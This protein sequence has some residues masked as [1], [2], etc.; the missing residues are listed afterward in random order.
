MSQHVKPLTAILIVI[1]TLVLISLIFWARGEA[2]RVGGPDQTQIDHA[3][4]LYIH[5]S[6]TLYIFS[7]D[8]ALQ[9]KLDLL[10][11]GVVDLVGDFAFFSNGDLLIR[12]GKFDPA[13]I[14]NIRRYQ[15]L[16]ETKAPVAKHKN[17]GMYRCNLEQMSCNK[18]GNNNIDFDSAFHLSVDPSTDTVYLSDTGRHK[19]RKFDSDGNTLAVQDKGFRFPNQ[20]L[21]HNN[22]LLVADTNHHA[23]QEVDT[24]NEN[25]GKIIQTNIVKN[26]SLGRHKWTFSMARVND[27]WW[28]NNMSNNMSN[29][30]I[31]VYDSNWNFV[32][33][34]ELPKKADPIDF[35][36]LQD[37]VLITDLDN[38]AIH[39][40]DY[41]GKL[42]TSPLP[43]EMDIKLQ[44][45]RK[46]KSRYEKL[47]IAAIVLFVLFIAGG[48]AL[49]ILQARRQREPAPELSSDE[50]F[51]DIN[52][53]AIKWVP[54]NKN[55]KYLLIVLIV[56][57]LLLI[58]LSVFLLVQSKPTEN[59]DILFPVIMLIA[60][61]AFVPFIV[62]KLMSYKIGTLNDLLV[63]KKSNRDFAAGKGRNIYYSD[64]HILIQQTYIPLNR[65][66]ML[67]ETQAIVTEVM[68]LLRDATFVQ[69]G[70][71]LNMILRRQKPFAII[72]VSILI[73]AIV[74]AILLHELV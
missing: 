13:L 45:L 32:K 11:L 71:M 14:D 51:F 28:V 20:I 65:Q 22:K 55:S 50:K 58:P 59:Q 56:I 61:L 63:I 49:A 64:T 44:E 18:F 5:I 29:G 35:A 72:S 68:P 42:L 43:E 6:G 25:F 52:H 17:E 19:L 26:K 2:L 41:N 36:V 23:I 67:F 8:F 40:L 21:L 57:P 47:A 10:E 12:K 74:L 60:L 48:F 30:K 34:V 70:E 62:Y 38:I 31:A 69:K 3:G 46:E 39:Q 73:A 1:V 9:R 16:P 54:R 66:Q 33:P 15:R 7:P 24:S 27:H 4:N 37:R 53:P